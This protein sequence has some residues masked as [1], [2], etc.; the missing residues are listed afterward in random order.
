MPPNHAGFRDGDG[1][2]AAD[3]LS[4]IG[5]TLKVD[6]GFDEKY[7]PR[8]PS[9]LA[10]LPVTGAWALIDTGAST[11]CIDT[12]LAMNLQLPIIDQRDCYGISGRLELNVHLAQIH[13]PTLQFTLYGSFLGV[14]LGGRRHTVLL[15]RDF[16]RHFEMIYDGPTGR[17]G[18]VDPLQPLPVVPVES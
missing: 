8:A 10:A 6:L 1:A 14:E 12:A 17:V 9:R 4:Q 11:S 3:L 15:G 16:L 18:L 7:D 5:P 2:S 13:V